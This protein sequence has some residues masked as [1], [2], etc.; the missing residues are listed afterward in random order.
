MGKFEDLSGRKFGKLTAIKI[1]EKRGKY[2]YYLCRCECGNLTV[3]R[4]NLLKNGYIKSCGCALKDRNK[5]P[6]KLNEYSVDGNEVFVKLS[7]TE[8]PMICD[9]D[10]WERLKKYTWC[11]SHYGYATANTTE[12][13]KRKTIKFHI[14]V[15]GKKNG[16][17]IDHIDRNPLNNKK[18]NLRFVE[19]R[20]NSINCGIYKNNT[21]GIKGVKRRSDTGKWSANIMVKYKNISLGCI[22][23]KPEAKVAREKAEQKY[24]YPLLE[25]R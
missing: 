9:I 18:D 10:D 19:Q 20:V 3:V 13:G 12:N 22:D 8:E 21:S 17:V 5:K 2:Y 24:F 6:K 25:T 1:S 23:T 7:N 16:M 14:E 11:K 15:L 4:G